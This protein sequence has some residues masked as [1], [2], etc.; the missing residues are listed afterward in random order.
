MYRNYVRSLSILVQAQM[1]RLDDYLTFEEI[2]ILTHP[3]GLPNQRKKLQKELH[4]YYEWGKL[5]ARKGVLNA[6]DGIL[7]LPS[8]SH[9]EAYPRVAL[10]EDYWVHKNDFKEFLQINDYWPLEEEYSL[11]SKWFVEH[12]TARYYCDLEELPEEQQAIVRKKWEIEDEQEIKK[13]NQKTVIL[14]QTRKNEL[15]ELT[16]DIF[17]SLLKEKGRIPTSQEVWNNIKRNYDDTDII[18]HASSESIEWK[19]WT[20]AEKTV[21]R[22]SFNNIYTKA[23]NF[24]CS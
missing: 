9:K 6:K 18:C 17:G 15:H 3:S 14:P 20:G 10:K 16:K 8:V 7:A 13:A 19:S 24:H 21:K 4:G 12:N 23:K 2:S 1:E 5:V 22:S 11:L